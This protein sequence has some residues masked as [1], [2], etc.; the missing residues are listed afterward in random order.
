LALQAEDAI[1]PE[2]DITSVFPAPLQGFAS[3]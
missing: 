1:I 2:F 3:K